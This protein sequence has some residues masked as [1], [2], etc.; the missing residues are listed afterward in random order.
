MEA[1]L[2]YLQTL[3]GVP[4]YALVLGLLLACGI[5]APMN[6]DIV[7]LIASA[8][9]LNGV[10][11]PV[12][13]MAVAWVGLIAGDALVFYWGHRYGA[14][15]L[16]SGYVS[17]IVPEGRLLSLQERVRR[18]GPFYI[19]VIRFLPGIRTALFFAAGSLKLPYRHLFI[20]DGAAALIELPL[21]VYGV[22]YVGG[23]WQ[24]IMA[25]FGRF[26]GAIVMA[27]L[28]LLVVWVLRGWHRRRAG[29]GGDFNEP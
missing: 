26:Q 9:T 11:D 14:R 12:A 8:L 2:Q 29:K 7:L 10:M 17:R 28:L 1:S 18:G 25:L 19:F 6:E 27:V 24:E 13:L 5:G 4:A 20:Y 23:R 22:R 3:Q 16:R 21:L 15:L